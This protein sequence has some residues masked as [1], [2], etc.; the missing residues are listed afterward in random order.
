[1]AVVD[2]DVYL[3]CECHCLISDFFVKIVE[4]DAIMT[5]LVGARQA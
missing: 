5:L 2:K 4:G 1:M 3:L